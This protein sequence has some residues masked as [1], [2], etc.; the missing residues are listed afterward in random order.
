M[1][2]IAVAEIEAVDIAAAGIAVGDMAMK[3][4]APRVT[5]SSEAEHTG[6]APSQMEGIGSDNNP[7]HSRA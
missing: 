7:N 4:F 2:D 1:A 3:E 5:P 6:T